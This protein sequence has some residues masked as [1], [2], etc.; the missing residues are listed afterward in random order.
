MTISTDPELHPNFLIFRDGPTL[1]VRIPG[2]ERLATNWD[3]PDSQAWQELIDKLHGFRVLK[4]D[5]DGQGADPPEPPSVDGAIQLAL[6]LSDKQTT[7]ADR[8]L[9]GVNGA[10]SFEW[11][12][13]DH[14]VEIEVV[15]L[16][17]AEIRSVDPKERSVVSGFIH[18]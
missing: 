13:F 16:N 6:E 5:W 1:D 12:S 7:P 15:E 18:W 2:H 9:V 4:F 3:L 11:I 17:K 8:V 14:Y 10:I